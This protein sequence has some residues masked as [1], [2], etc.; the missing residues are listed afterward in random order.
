MVGQAIDNLAAFVASTPLAAIPRPV[1]QH[2]RLVMLDT[3][4]VTLAGSLR[5]EVRAIRGR[6]CPSDAGTATVFAAPPTQTDPRT[7]ALLNAMSGRAVEL[8]EG[9]RLASGQVAVQVLPGVLAVAESRNSTGA[10]IVAAFVLGYEAAARLCVALTARPLAHQNGQACLIGAV[11]ATARLHGLDGAGI[12]RA[13]RIAATLLLTPSY[14]GAVAGAT[15]LN[16]AGGMSGFAAALAPELAQAGYT[17]EPDAVEQALG[18]M[19]GNG[20]DPSGLA[21]GLGADWSITRNYFRLHACCNPI[22]PALDCI[23]DAFAQLSPAPEEIEAIEVETYRFAS[24]MAAPEPANWFASKYSLPHAAATLAV[25]GSTDHAALDDGA[26][27]DP[28]IAA[29]R[30]RVHVREDPDMS[31]LVPRLKPARA[32]VR[33][34]DGRTVTVARDSHRGDFMDPFP[35]QAIRRKFQGLAA[36]V[37]DRDG[38]REVEAAIDACES[39]VSARALPDLL[40]R[41]GL[42]PTATD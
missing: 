15:V 2:A 36:S 34:R 29:L 42:V 12:S 27:H 6:L 22:H 10:E 17:A 39:W 41:H 4:G 8:C 37:L 14:T 9:L 18:Q 33:M 35:E 1:R 11:A 21:V 7:A 26:L 32:T 31:V 24:V 13:M 38:V 25:R 30:S 3:V 19:V 16:V 20:F 28:G 5:P 40:R 23:A